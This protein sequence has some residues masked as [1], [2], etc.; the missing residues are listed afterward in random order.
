MNILITNDDGVSAIGIDVLRRVASE[1]GQ[2]TVVAPEHQ[3]SGCGHNTT[4]DRDLHINDLGGGRY[5]VNGTPVDCIRLAITHLGGEFD[6][7]LSGIND[8][9]NLGFDVY[10]SGTVGAAREA[11]YRG[12]P[13]IALSQYCGKRNSE[14]RWIKSEHYAH[15]M[16]RELLIKKPNPRKFWNVNFPD[17]ET[18]ESSIA[19]HNGKL[20]CEIVHCELDHS[21]LPLAYQ[22]EGNRFTPNG[23]YHLRS[24]ESGTDIDVCFSGDISVTMV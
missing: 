21:P 6:W 12:F 14:S 20:N 19:Q 1:F 4:L 3:Q 16:L 18:E 24:R 17:I 7:V 8:G 13:A 22:A 11:A 10:L 5:S 23:D 9:A 15:A 2:V